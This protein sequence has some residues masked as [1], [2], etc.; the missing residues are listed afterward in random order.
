ME[1]PRATYDLSVSELATLMREQIRHQEEVPDCDAKPICIGPAGIIA[2]S[3][4]L[5]GDPAVALDLIMTAVGELNRLTRERDD[6]VRRVEAQRDVATDMMARHE[7][8][9]TTASCENQRLVGKVDALENELA[10][11]QAELTAWEESADVVGPVLPIADREV[12]PC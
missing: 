7:K 5:Y 2:L 10:V 9:L 8:T 1:D 11:V 4:R 3:T 12:G 6:A